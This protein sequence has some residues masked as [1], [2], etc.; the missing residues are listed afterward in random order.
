M[1]KKNFFE[2]NDRI[3]CNRILKILRWVNLAF[4]AIFLL[5]IIGLFNITYSYLFLLAIAGIITTSIPQFLNKL[6][7]STTIIK[8]SSVIC[9]GTIVMLMAMNGDIGIYMT[10][11]LIMLLSCMFYDKKFTIHVCII[12]YIQIIISLFVRSRNVDIAN[13]ATP[14]QWFI[15]IL[16]GFTIEAVI[17]SAV[18]IKLAEYSRTMLEKL[19]EKQNL[20]NIVSICENASTK[21]ASTVDVLHNDITNSSETNQLIAKSSNRTIDDLQESKLHVENTK[22]SINEM[23]SAT[24]TITL[25]TDELLDITSNTTTQMDSYAKTIDTTVD[26][27]ENIKRATNT[28]EESILNL[29]NG[30]N[31]IASFA[32][33]ISDITSQTNLL[34]LN[35]SIEA[36]R[37]GEHGKGFSVVAE[38][39]R[40]LA[41]RSKESS[42]AIT[43]IINKIYTLLDEVK[44][45]NKT[46]INLVNN[47]INKINSI[48][49]DTEDIYNLQANI[50][51]M[52][53]EIVHYCNTS[54][55]HNKNVEE[56]IE[57]LNTIVASSM[58]RAQDIVNETKNQMEVLSSVQNSFSNVNEISKELLNISKQTSSL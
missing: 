7:K 11:A 29:A 22:E 10:Y 18:S 39:V 1:N 27:M 31:D 54:K 25:K 30:I 48:K 17:M 8:Y 49:K 33:E 16:A 2:E 51:K 26:D 58:D 12:S 46:N 45:S 44:S 23:S 37:A 15:A 55:T 13:G 6:N 32:N 4:P 50:K 3:T 53:E 28:T 34:A 9:L 36:A 56:M 40:K 43:N 41:E 57:K 5:N 38:S 19:H 21:L 47:G 20:E 14:N 42:D 24:E 35:A 52:T